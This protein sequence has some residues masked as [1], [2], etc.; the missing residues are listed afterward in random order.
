M[1]ELSNLGPKYFIGVNLKV[2]K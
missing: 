1:K 2:H